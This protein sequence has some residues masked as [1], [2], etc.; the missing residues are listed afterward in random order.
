MPSPTSPANGPPPG[1]RGALPRPGR[2][3][4]RPPPSFSGAGGSGTPRRG[5]ARLAA[6]LPA[7][8]DIRCREPEDVQVHQ[9]GV[10]VLEPLGADDAFPILVMACSCRKP[11]IRR[12]DAAPDE[13]AVTPRPATLDD[14]RGTC[15]TVQHAAPSPAGAAADQKGSPGCA[16]RT[17]ERHAG[18]GSGGADG[19]FRLLGMLA[20]RVTGEVGQLALSGEGSGSLL[21]PA[22]LVG[23]MVGAMVGG[24]FLPRQ[25]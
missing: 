23:A 17:I 7:A 14:W 22:G 20:Q 6:L 4:R 13:W 16:R 10:D 15:T 8:P 18:L 11:I 1:R 12:E 9:G 2:H 25:S 21:I 5:S 3:G 19:A 24:F